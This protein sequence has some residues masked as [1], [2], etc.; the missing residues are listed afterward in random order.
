MLCYI[1]F[2]YVMLCHVMSCHVMLYIFILLLL[3]CYINVMIML[4]KVLLSPMLGKIFNAS[5]SPEESHMLEQC[6]KGFHCSKLW[7]MTAQ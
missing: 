3:L 2:C 6:E 4:L 7:C 1:M 5:G